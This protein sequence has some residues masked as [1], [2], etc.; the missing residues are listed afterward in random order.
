[1]GIST[2]RHFYCVLDWSWRWRAPWNRQTD[3]T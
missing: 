2:R 3:S 1:M